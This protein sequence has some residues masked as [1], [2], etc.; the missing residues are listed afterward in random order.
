MTRCAEK[1]LS[2]PFS[3]QT[4]LSALTTDQAMLP[5][6]KAAVAFGSLV[7]L[8]SGM[9]RTSVKW[10]IQSLRPLLMNERIQEWAASCLFLLPRVLN[11]DGPLLHHLSCHYRIY[12]LHALLVKL[13]CGILLLEACECLE[14]C[15]YIP[16]ATVWKLREQKDSKAFTGQ[17]A[18][19]SSVW[20]FTLCLCI[21]YIG[22]S[23]AS[24]FLTCI[25]LVRCF[26]VGFSLRSPHKRG[27]Y[28]KW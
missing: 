21:L 24:P 7:T 13:F 4:L 22:S 28:L 2:Q 19:A 14:L 20:G 5:K 25:S 17:A 16:R 11:G 18:T 23:V 26:Q 9:G 6:S 10:V 1:P 3:I 8:P 12:G 27:V 15:I